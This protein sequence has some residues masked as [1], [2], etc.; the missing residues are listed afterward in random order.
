MVGKKKLQMMMYFS[1]SKKSVFLKCFPADI[2][3]TCHPSEKCQKIPEALWNKLSSIALS[4]SIHTKDHEIVM[5]Q[6]D[7]Y[8]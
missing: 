7:Q 2:L 6:M 3:V 5:T 1:L 8:L 4:L